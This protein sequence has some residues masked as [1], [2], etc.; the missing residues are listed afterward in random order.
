MDI[1][2]S[3]IF[4]TSMEKNSQ[5]TCD[6]VRYPIKEIKDRVM[7]S[8]VRRRLRMSNID[9]GKIRVLLTHGFRTHTLEEITSDIA[10]FKNFRK[11]TCLFLSNTFQYI[12]VSE[13]ESWRLSEYVKR[14]KMS[15][16]SERDQDITNPFKIFKPA[17]CLK[18]N[19]KKI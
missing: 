14:G 18:I 19:T 4:D 7:M 10:I 3:S 11:Y 6:S 17:P 1:P 15:A 5:E 13:E 9:A 12:G 16:F 2:L 8:M